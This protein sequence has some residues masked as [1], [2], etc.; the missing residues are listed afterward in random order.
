[1]KSLIGDLGASS[2]TRQSALHRP[3][4]F[5]NKDIPVQTFQRRGQRWLVVLLL[6]TLTSQL[7]SPPA[8]KG[9][10][11]AGGTWRAAG[12]VSFSYCGA[13]YMMFSIL[14]SC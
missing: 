5:G 2:K 11:H 13:R 9:L 10:P 6:G 3:A 7:C 14:A 8:A 4:Q 1:M 12:Y